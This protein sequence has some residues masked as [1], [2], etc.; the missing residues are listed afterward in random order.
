MVLPY[1]IGEATAELHSVMSW[2]MEYSDAVDTVI[3]TRTSLVRDLQSNSTLVS[4]LLVHHLGRYIPG[5]FL[6][7]CLV[8]KYGYLYPGPFII[9]QVNTS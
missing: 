6:R 7:L 1:R 2:V 5:F 4:D 3:D 9:T 8:T